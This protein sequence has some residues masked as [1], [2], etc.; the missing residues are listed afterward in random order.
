MSHP[1]NEVTYRA[2]PTLAKFHKS[3]ARVRC[4]VGPYGS[5]KSSAS[6][7]EAFIRAQRQERG[8]DGKRRTRGVIIRNTY[9]ELEDT[10]RRTFEEWIPR[11]LKAEWHEASNSCFIRFN[12]VEMEVLFRALDKP[13][14]VAKL[15]SLEITWAW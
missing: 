3:N 7:M 12:D 1:S 10:T 14:D 15:L 5:G 11:G 9:R 13:Q 2:A 4:L 8:P 6:S